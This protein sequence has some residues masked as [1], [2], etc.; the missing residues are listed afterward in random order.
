MNKRFAEAADITSDYRVDKSK[1][2]IFKG[3]IF[4]VAAIEW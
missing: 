2:H 1:S 3:F 4:I